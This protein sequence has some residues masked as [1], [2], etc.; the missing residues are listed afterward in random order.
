[1][2]QT[3]EQE[4]VKTILANADTCREPSQAELLNV[5]GLAGES[6]HNAQLHMAGLAVSLCTTIGGDI[7]S[8]RGALRARRYLA[9]PVSM[10][11]AGISLSGVQD[12][13]AQTAPSATEYYKVLQGVQ[14]WQRGYMHDCYVEMP[15][16]DLPDPETVTKMDYVKIEAILQRTR[17]LGHPALNMLDQARHLTRDELT[18]DALQFAEHLVGYIIDQPPLGDPPIPG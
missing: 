4:H 18:Q 14:A 6:E 16:T 7:M 11:P 17:A 10:L 1:M 5:M 15:V 3:P 9:L 2:A 8:Y 13:L 12:A